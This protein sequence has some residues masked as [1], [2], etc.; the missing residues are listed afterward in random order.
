MTI[1]FM[2]ILLMCFH[3]IPHD[4]CTTENRET[5]FISGR[6]VSSFDECKSMIGTKVAFSS[7][8]LPDPSDK[9]YYFIGACRAIDV[10]EPLKRSDMFSHS[11]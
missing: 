7:D 10:P 5:S 9:S 4:K 1:A 8:L 6:P 2:P 11:Q 3:T